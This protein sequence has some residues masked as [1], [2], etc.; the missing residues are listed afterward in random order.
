MKFA[1]QFGS[2]LFASVLSLSV[3]GILF[4]ELSGA[5]AA[6]AAAASDDLIGILDG[7]SGTSAATY[8]KEQAAQAASQLAPI[9]KDQGPEAKVFLNYFEKGDFER[10]LF[11][12]PVAFGGKPFAKTANGK[13]LYGLI[14]VKNSLPV[15]GIETLFSV[16]HPKEIAPSLIA[17][18]KETVTDAHPAWST[19]SIQWRPEWTE[20]FGTG[21]EV[22]VISRNQFA[23]DQVDRLK[24]AIK[25]T[26][27]GTRERALL[28][29]QLV[30]ALSVQD[31]AGDAAKLLAHLMKAPNNP[32]S[33]DLMTITAARLLFQNGYLDAATNYYAKIPKSS[34]YWLD[35]QEEL[36]WTE[37]RKAQP[38]NVLAITRTLV[39]PAFSGQVGPETYV[40]RSLA[41][42]KVCDYPG[43][44]ESMK[45]FREQFRD[46]AL[47]LQ[48]LKDNA[49]T[50]PV[51]RFV[52]LEEA[53]PLKLTDEGADIHVLP[54]YITRDFVLQD[55][56]AEGR[57]LRDEGKHAGDLFL[58][59]MNYEGLQPGMQAH[60]QEAKA[61]IEQRVRSGQD[62]IYARVKV[63]AADEVSEIQAQLQK[64]HIVETEVL[65]HISLAEK[66]IQASKGQKPSNRLG[67]T[68]SQSRDRLTF[69]AETETWFDELANFKVD[70][71]KGCQAKAGKEIM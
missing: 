17:L 70:V 37:M 18:W 3:S 19:V 20:I 41:Q 7:D 39:H 30:L 47:K 34:D 46:R 45:T 29:W 26:T 44:V 66:R 40:L 13:A 8:N 48:A 64:M 59:A 35:A 25:K 56:I 36:G 23:P 62:A 21:T 28:E 1:Q 49:A 16:D 68:G 11:H 9:V 14:L 52:K 2:Y 55:L 50:P 51:E 33:T 27:L 60:L 63:L 43:V 32:I 58:R 22:R 6:S 5:Q 38:Q 4:G 24:E 57:A 53:K 67:T 10:A 31:K 15:S 12:W 69:P 65:Q 42:L 71:S 61:S 54:R